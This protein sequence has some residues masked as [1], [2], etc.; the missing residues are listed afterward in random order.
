MLFDNGTPDLE[1]AFFADTDGYGMQCAENFF[2]IA[3]STGVADITG[4]EWFGVYYGN[5]AP[6]ADAFTISFYTLEAGS[7]PAFS[8]FRTI[9]AGAANRIDTGIDFLANGGATTH[10]VYSYSVDISALTLNM[11]GTYFISIS[12]SS[13]A[14]SSSDDWLWCSSNNVGGRFWYRY[15]YDMWYTSNDWPYD[16]AFNLTGE[17]HENGGVYPEPSSVCL[18]AIGLA[19]LAA[20]RFRNMLN[21]GNR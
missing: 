16:L 5:N 12:N 19:G 9:D 3:G 8:A 17:I 20:R 1:A 7:R 14:S 15:G 11:S 10:D 4:I 18:V 13:P 21:A 6:E 2:G